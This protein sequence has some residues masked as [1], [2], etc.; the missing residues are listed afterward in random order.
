MAVQRPGTGTVQGTVTASTVYWRFYC[1]LATAEAA[2]ASSR[3]RFYVNLIRALK[4][5]TPPRLLR[6]RPPFML[7]RV[8]V[9]NRSGRYVRASQL[10]HYT[11]LCSVEKLGCIT[12]CDA[13]W[14]S[15]TLSV[16]TISMIGFCEAKAGW[17]LLTPILVIR[18]VEYQWYTHTNAHL[19]VQNLDAWAPDQRK[20]AMIHHTCGWPPT[21]LHICS[22]L[23]IC[24]LLGRIV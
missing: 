23:F 19:D 8:S 20:S 16:R 24:T 2:L 7:P 4:L 1:R 13:Q 15:A 3:Y 11:E 21:Y 10:V 17:E 9:G 18:D 5:G 12:N 14:L 6:R 22:S